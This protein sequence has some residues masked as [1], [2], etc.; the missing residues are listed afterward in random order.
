MKL[1]RTYK[2]RIYPNREQKS[3][4]DTALDTTDLSVLDAAGKVKDIIMGRGGYEPG[5][6]DWSE[7]FF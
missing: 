3:I 4:L 7:D 1:K 2:Y 5:K 6:I